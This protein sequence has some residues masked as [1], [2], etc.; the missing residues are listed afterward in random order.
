MTERLAELA[1]RWR[2]TVDLS[3]D[4]ASSTIAYARRGDEPVVL[5]VVKQPG[6]EWRSGDVLRAFDGRGMVRVF[7]HVDGAVLLERLDP[8]SPLVDLAQRGDDEMATAILCDV[9]RAMEPRAAPAWCPTVRDWAKGFGRYMTSGDRRIAPNLVARAERCFR[10][11]CD[12]QREP[13]LLHGDLHHSNVLFDRDRGWVAIDPK[14]VIG[15][16]EY[17]VGAALRNPVECPEL[18]GDRVILERR[19]TM[20]VSRL[21]L[22]RQRVIGWGFAQAVLS[23]IWDVEDG[24]VVDDASSALGL[25]AALLPMLDE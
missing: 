11:L 14:G 4:T 10:T 12:S 6:D 16:P 8:A 2:V 19:L 20:Y 15:E 7:E 18:I 5:K 24:H 13:R 9:I 21:V 17:E 22:D 25:A 23:A 3:I 1:R